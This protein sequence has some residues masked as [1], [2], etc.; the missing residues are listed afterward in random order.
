MELPIPRL[1]AIGMS[2]AELQKLERLFTLAQPIEQL[3]MRQFFASKVESDLVE[4]L[5]AQRSVGHFVVPPTA[6]PVTEDE[7]AMLDMFVYAWIPLSQKGA[8]EGVATLNSGGQILES[9]LPPSVV[10]SSAAARG[11]TPVPNG[12]GGYSWETGVGPAIDL[13]EIIEGVKQE[14]EIAKALNEAMATLPPGAQVFFPTLTAPILLSGAE[15][16][17]S[18]YATVYLL[19]KAIEVTK[20]LTLCGPG[21]L[22]GGVLLRAKTGFT[23]SQLVRNWKSGDWQAGR[24]DSSCGVTK[25]SEVVTDAS[26]EAGDVGKLVR[27]ARAS[28]PANLGYLFG[29]PRGATITAVTPGVSFTMSKAYIGATGTISCMVG[30]PDHQIAPIKTSVPIFY[31]RM[32]DLGLDPFG[33]NNV[34]CVGRVHPQEQS[35]LRDVVYRSYN[36]G[37]ASGYYGRTDFAN[38]DSEGGSISGI[39]ACTGEVSYGHGWVSMILQDGSCGGKMTP[40]YP[41]GGSVTRDTTTAVSPEAAATNYSSSPLRFIGLSHLTLGPIHQEGHPPQTGGATRTFKDG[42][43]AGTAVLKTAGSIIFSGAFAGRT[44]TDSEGHIPAG[45]II[46]K[47]ISQTEMELSNVATFSSGDELTIGP[48]DACIRIIDCSGVHINTPHIAAHFLTKR[49]W[50]RGT[51]SERNPEREPMSPFIIT[52]G[53]LVQNI[54]ENKYWEAGAPVI[55]DYS[56]DELLRRLVATS[57]AFDPRHVSRYDGDEIV[58]WDGSTASERRARL[59]PRTVPDSELWTPARQGLLAAN[60]DPANLASATLTPTAGVLQLAWIPT[61]WNL[62]ISEIWYYLAEQSGNTFTEKQNFVGLYSAA[63]KL[64]AQTK[65]L[66]ATWGGEGAHAQKVEQAL[67]RNIGAPLNY[68]GSGVWLG[69]LVNGTIV[70]MKFGGIGASAA[71]LIVPGGKQYSRAASIG[72]ALTELPTSFTPSELAALSKLAWGGLS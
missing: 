46:T 40:T 47:Y 13:R 63:G 10:S 59:K 36:S 11:Q 31:W 37:S 7:Q 12:K 33:N 43:M 42:S 52:A 51:S 58:W 44:I 15:G 4:W 29:I 60:G 30:E 9:E 3:A 62:K 1:Q 66:S 69:I 23:D 50:V 54:G 56:D 28:E 49:P 55:E 5:N 24:T 70:K 68:L 57:E 6:G 41:T 34:T 25:G 72:T 64:I 61:P 22:N 35:Y 71:N 21:A 20:E 48:D 39:Q 16:V 17:P 45:T 65:D 19:E 26:C 38:G 53:K 14:A 18:H 27:D 67:W 32:H 8:P 2:T